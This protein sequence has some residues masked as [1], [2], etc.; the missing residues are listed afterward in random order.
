MSP[1]ECRK[2]EPAKDLERLETEVCVLRAQ[3]GDA[4]AFRR[5]VLLYEGR[6][7]YFIRRMVQD[8]DRALDVLQDVWLT[9]FRRLHSL[10]SPAA[11]KTWL[12]RI[13][14]GKAVDIV[15]RERRESVISANS[16]LEEAIADDETGSERFEN[17][18]L[19]HRAL[20]QLSLLHREVL[21]LRFL[22]DLELAEIAEIV[23]CTLGTAK[24]RLHYAKL[25][26]RRK[27]EELV[28]E[29]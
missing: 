6:L 15:R 20:E 18:E 7:L 9:A 21:T 29:K 14:H 17:A 19:V 8:A 25:A 28:H 1:Q 4:D 22:E 3:D 24:S 5:L 23:G 2:V 11:F 13:A 10:R 16:E 27:V 12:Y 26:L